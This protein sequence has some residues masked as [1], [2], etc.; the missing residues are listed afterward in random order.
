VHELSPRGRE[1]VAAAR[2]LLEEEGPDALS[3]RRLAERVGIKAPSI[4]KHLP[5]KRA[6]EV[7][8]IAAGFEELIA[9]HGETAGDLEDLG[10]VWRAFALD[11]PHLYRLMTLQPLPRD[12]LPEGLEARAAQPVIE[13]AGGDEHRA[14][15]IFAFAHGMA[16]LELDQRFPE[17]ADVAAAWHAGLTAF[18]TA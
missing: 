4:Y 16:I 8:L 10:R 14:R 2:E 15:A 9:R 5:D 1:L 7:A 17:G 12:Q 11:H 3:M 18:A 6:L 13:A